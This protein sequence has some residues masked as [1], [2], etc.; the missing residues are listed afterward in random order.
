M[1]VI[2]MTD[3]VSSADGDIPVTPHS[4]MSQSTSLSEKLSAANAEPRNPASVMHI[5]MVDK[6]PVGSV[7]MR[8][9]PAAFLSPSSAMRRTFVSFSD[10]TAISVAANRAF[11]AISAS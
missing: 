11:T 2:I 1:S 9:I 7:T 4:F 3:T 10:I 8:S 5:W 6:K